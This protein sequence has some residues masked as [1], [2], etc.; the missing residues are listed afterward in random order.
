MAAKEARLFSETL[1]WLSPA[2]QQDDETTG[3]TG[4][5]GGDRASY[6]LFSP[7]FWLAGGGVQPVSSQLPFQSPMTDLKDSSLSLL[8]QI[9]SSDMFGHADNV[10]NENSFQ[11]WM[12]YKLST[13]RVGYFFNCCFILLG[14]RQQ[15]GTRKNQAESFTR[16]GL[17][18]AEDDEE[19]QMKAFGSESAERLFCLFRSLSVGVREMSTE[20]RCV[21][22]DTGEEERLERLPPQLRLD[23][24]LRSGLCVWKRFQVAAF[25]VCRRAGWARL[26]VS[27]L[28]SGSEITE[29]TVFYCCV[30]PADPLVWT[31][32]HTQQLFL[33]FFRSLWINYHFPSRP[34]Q[35]EVIY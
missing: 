30:Y 19:P 14:E 21:I 2:R 24:L 23:P 1:V 3:V 35:A 31:D 8:L 17:G 5:F 9:T 10:L 6:L 26:C 34:L 25:A 12:G 13:P 18:F 28:S 33:H 11:G 7:A 4:V 20:L 32:V 22:V 16:P 15:G 27:A 29:Q